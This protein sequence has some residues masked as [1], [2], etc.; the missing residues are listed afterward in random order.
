[1]GEV[2]ALF[3]CW[4]ALSTK[5]KMNKY[6][7][8]Y[9]DEVVELAASGLNKTQAIAKAQELGSEGHF[10]VRVRLEDPHHPTWPFNFDLREKE[11]EQSN[12]SN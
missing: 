8:C 2:C 3:L 4:F 10:H 6:I 11:D 12:V 1:M 5:H 7:V 9:G